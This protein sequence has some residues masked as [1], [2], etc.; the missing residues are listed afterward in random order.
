MYYPLSHPPGLRPPAARE[1]RTQSMANSARIDE[2]KKKFDE[3]PRRYFAPL[4]NEYRKSGDLAQAVFILE[5]YLP[6]QPGHMS[7]H[8]VYG[9]TLFELGRDEEA[10]R[11]FETALSLDPENLI[12]LRHLGHI[13]RQA[14][15]FDSARSWYQRLLEADP[16]DAEIEQLLESLDSAAQ[17]RAAA[18]L[19]S[20]ETDSSLPPPLPPPQFA[21]AE[22]SSTLE[23]EHVVEQD[24]PSVS[25]PTTHPLAPPPMREPT[26]AIATP[27]VE[28]AAEPPAE[29][30]EL[31]DIADFSI[32]GEPA[33]S[34]PSVPDHTDAS[35]PTEAMPVADA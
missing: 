19:P 23:V 22:E 29:S 8:V 2:L 3:N 33:A 20:T 6:Q 24:A 25:R 31:L 26:P 12:A 1:K 11:V 32:G 10:K 21:A 7:G 30:E 4:A 15:D 28:A 9:Q 17:A 34:P 14:A 13:A 5:E 35:T 27:V 16:R 18:P